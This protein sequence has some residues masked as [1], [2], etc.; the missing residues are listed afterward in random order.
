MGFGVGKSQIGVDTHDFA[1]G[2]HFRTQGDI[3]ALITQKRKHRFLHRVVF[4][5]D[6]TC[7]AKLAQGFADHH[8]GCQFG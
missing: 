3:H 8:F 5:H 2:F 7:K 1:G 4:R 6:F